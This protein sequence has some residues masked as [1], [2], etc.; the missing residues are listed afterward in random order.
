MIRVFNTDVSVQDIDIDGVDTP[1]AVV[2]Q[3]IDLSDA[4]RL[5]QHRIDL[6]PSD[7]DPDESREIAIPSMDALVANLEKLT[8][9]NGE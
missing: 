3:H 6:L 4:I 9:A 7:P 8:S 1:V 5:A 2:I